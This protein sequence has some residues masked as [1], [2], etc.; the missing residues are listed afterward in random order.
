M[1]TRRRAI[2]GKWEAVEGTAEN[3]IWS[4]GG[5]L[6][7][8]P[9]VEPDFKMYE[10]QVVINSLSQMQDI[11]GGTSMKLT[12]GAELKGPGVAY[13][14]SVKPAL[15]KYLVGCGFKEAFTNTPGT[16]KY[17]YT[18]ASTRDT[19]QMQSMTMTLFADGLALKMKGAR[20][21][22]HFTGKMGEPMIPE[23][24]FQGIYVSTIDATMI[25]PTFE[26]TVPPT[27]LSSQLT[28]DAVST[29]KAASIDINMNNT[30]VLREDMNAAEGYLSCM[31]TGRKPNGKIDPEM[32]L[33]SVYDFMT[34]WRTGVTAVLSLGVIGA[35][36]YNRWKIT[37]PVLQYTKIG[38]AERTSLAVADTNFALKGSAGDDE[39]VIEF[40]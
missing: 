25:T 35:T 14:A 19:A 27:L 29:L 12:F 37:A 5:I 38:D 40:S 10:R 8:N 7:I 28:L 13:S 39:I 18:P 3:P 4:D 21:N 11:P 36:Q 24:E 1:L 34:K 32:E 31:I 16:E 23:F 33:V 22:V 30:L 2:A 9:K 20:G 6:I 26:T 15:G 17:T